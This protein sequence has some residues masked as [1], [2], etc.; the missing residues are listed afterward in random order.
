MSATPSGLM[1]VHVGQPPPGTDEDQ[2]LRARAA[3]SKQRGHRESAPRVPGDLN[4]AAHGL[5]PR[6]LGEE[7]SDCAVAIEP[8]FFHGRGADERNRFLAGAARR[9]ETALVVSLIGDTDSAGYSH[10]FSPFDASVHVGEDIL[11]SVA[12]RRLPTGPLL[13]LVSGT[14]RADRDLALRLRNQPPPVWWALEVQG[15]TTHRGG[16]FGR[17]TVHEPQGRMEPILVNNLGEPVVGAWTPSDG[18]QRWYVLP[19]GV[20]WNIVL[21]WLIQQA[22]PQFAPTAL[23]RV[24]SPHFLDPATQSVDELAAQQELDDLAAR[25]SEDK[26]RIEQRL[27]AAREQAEP[28]RHG[29]LYGSGTSLVEAVHA[30]FTAA[31]LHVVDLDAELGATK[32]ADLLIS[33]DGASPRRLVEIKGVSGRAS[34]NLVADLQRH[35]NTWPQLRPDVPVTSGV[36]VVNHQHKLDPAQRDAEVYTRKEFVDALPVTVLG[37]RRVFEWW[38]VRDWAALRTAVLGSDTTIA[39]ST[40]ADRQAPVVPAARRGRGWRRRR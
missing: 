39:A 22:V 5:R 25:Y 35:L 38:R 13:E 8:G 3:R 10:P 6:W 40:P 27:R 21:D 14:G 17:P 24:R 31:G 20:D 18:G 28:L 16:G 36:L 11:T 7:T 9:G 37:T 34:E 15:A 33:L 2:P 4:W 19:D 26:L 1:P 23:R 30:V 12:G 32:S 29:L